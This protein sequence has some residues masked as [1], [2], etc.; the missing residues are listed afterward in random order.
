MW[1]GW[2][3][4]AEYINNILHLD[5]AVKTTP[6]QND[7]DLVKGLRE[8]GHQRCIQPF[9]RQRAKAYR[10]AAAIRRNPRLTHDVDSRQTRRLRV[11]R[12]KQKLRGT[13]KSHT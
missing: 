9:T 6:S 12:Y 4:N 11:K 1:V 10:K 3:K 7:L 5:H 8:S 2:V 13:K